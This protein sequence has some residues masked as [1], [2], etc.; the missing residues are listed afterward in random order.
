MKARFVDGGLFKFG[1]RVIM[2]GGIYCGFDASLYLASLKTSESASN[3]A[4][5]VLEY[6]APV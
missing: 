1:K 4:A 3:L 2:S 6:I 5:M